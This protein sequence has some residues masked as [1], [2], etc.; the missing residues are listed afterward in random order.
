MESRS[1]FFVAQLLFQFQDISL[2]NI[3]PTTISL[4][5]F[6]PKSRFHCLVF[7]RGHLLTNQD[8]SW[9][10]G[11]VEIIAMQVNPLKLPNA[12]K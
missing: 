2:Q 4:V 11:G 7:H 5:A 9:I 10:W 6:P 8:D 1:F 3:L 12:P